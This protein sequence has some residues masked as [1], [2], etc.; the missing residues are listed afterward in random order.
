MAESAAR[1]DGVTL[2]AV[3]A[4]RADNGRVVVLVDQGGKAPLLEYPLEDS[5][6]RALDLY[7]RLKKSKGE[8]GKYTEASLFLRSKTNR[9]VKFT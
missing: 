2:T 7:A 1:A 5:S 8:G 9:R 4:R 3:V 6:D